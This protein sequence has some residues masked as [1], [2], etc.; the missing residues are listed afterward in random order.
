MRCALADF[1]DTRLSSFTAILRV[2]G[3]WFSVLS[4]FGAGRSWSKSDFGGRARDQVRLALRARL[5]LLLRLVAATRRR[6][7]LAALALRSVL[8][9]ALTVV[10]PGWFAAPRGVP[11]P[12]FTA[13]TTNAL[14]VALPVDV[15]TQLVASLT[16][17]RAAQLEA[18]PT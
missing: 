6:P 17:A 7:P 5:R 13:A 11:N 15:K 9:H 4:L 18:A 14:S 8:S 3:V 1:S 10:A 2:V 16:I 12:T